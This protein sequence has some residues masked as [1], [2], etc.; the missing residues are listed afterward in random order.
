MR[1]ITLINVLLYFGLTASAQQDS[2]M[3]MFGKKGRAVKVN[4][5]G[6]ILVQRTGDSI[7]LSV[8]SGQFQPQLLTDGVNYLVNDSLFIKNLCAIMGSSARPFF[9]IIGNSIAVGA[10]A[11]SIDSSYPEIVKRYI[12]TK[13]NQPA[14]RY[15]FTNFYQITQGILPIDGFDSIS[16][17]W[18]SGGAGANGLYGGNG[19]TFYFHGAYDFN[20]V[21]FSNIDAAYGASTTATFNPDCS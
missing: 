21:F 19:L 12:Q 6:T 10:A 17:G 1:I 16:G 13:T 5:S 8:A 18:N 3:F 7:G 14:D 20:E 2:S 11:T 4:N 9:G 15:M